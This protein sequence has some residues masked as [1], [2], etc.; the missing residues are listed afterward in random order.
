MKKE[1]SSFDLMAI[2][3]EL[4]SLVGARLDKIYQKGD[5]FIL[6]INVPKLGK[7]E[8][9]IKV[10]KWI[11]LSE[12]LEKPEIV[13]P[14]AAFLRKVLAN[15]VIKGIEQR[16][17][18]RILVFK[19]QK[20]EEYEMVLEMFGKGNLVLIRNGRI[21]R[22]FHY[23]TWKGRD[24]RPGQEY[25][26]PPI[27]PNPIK[28]SFEDF[29][30]LL[31]ASEKS[32]VSTLATRVNLGGRYAEE[33]CLLCGIDKKV[34][35]RELKDKDFESI[36]TR[37]KDLFHQVK[38]RRKPIVVFQDGKPFDASPLE[39]QQY[40]NLEKKELPSFSQALSY[41][42]EATKEVEDVAEKYRRRLEQQE[43]ALKQLEAEEKKSGELAE[44]LYANFRSI[45]E[46]LKTIRD[47]REVEDPRIKSLDARKK[48]VTLTLPS[49]EYLTIDFSK[50]VNE[51]AKLLYERRKEVRRKATKVKEAIEATRKDMKRSLR[52]K[53]GK[54]EVPRK[55][56]KKFWFEAYRWFLSKEG[57]LVLGGRDA[58]GN[59]KLVKKHLRGGDRYAHAD[60][61]GAPSIVIKDGS[62]ATQ[63]TLREACQFALAFSKAWKDKL[64]SGS[65]YWV[66]PEQVSKTAESGEFLQKGAFV[67]R[68]KRNY[69]HKL[70][71]RLAIG[72]IQ[73]QNSK[74]IMCGPPDALKVR[75]R[76]YIE[77]KPGK[78]NKND[79]ARE[80]SEFF[81]VPIEEIVTVLP[82]GD[83]EIAGRITREHD[84]R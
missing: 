38:E 80:L 4:Q 60:I 9:Y 3:E 72:E 29:S 19:L 67:I 30:S 37:L 32:L 13:P 76:K 57:Y 73:Y 36:Q 26:Y 21:I 28:M 20:E 45:E 7:R 35:I 66:L 15:A 1:M 25:Y 47:N 63:E 62:N 53:I 11:F 56:T 71:I 82:P 46:L 12:F 78:K 16:E 54:E 64:A 43:E 70:E 33:I 18:D 77:F 55:P 75:S 22:H 24:I 27:G 5:E 61:S 23:K 83:V 69:F 59:E 14:F 48:L 81:D 42:I 8:I 6:R 2:V 50:D 51:N 65:A 49:G 52:E 31:R 10:G 44:Y 74:K 68:G 40:A 17:F 79:F 39:L 41:Y 84:K 34:G 58:K